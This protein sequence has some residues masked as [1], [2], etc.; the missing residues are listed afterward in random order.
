M[1][2][3]DPQTTQGEAESTLP[4]TAQAQAPVPPGK[5]PAMTNVPGLPPTG[6]AMQM[7]SLNEQIEQQR[8][9]DEAGGRQAMGAHVTRGTPQAPDLFQPDPATSRGPTPIDTTG[10]AGDRGV[11][12]SS[13]RDLA[14]QMARGY[15]LNFS[16]GSLVDD[17]G[18]FTMTP[19]QLTELQGEGG[20]LSDTAANMNRI[21][22]AINDQKIQMQQDK[23]TAALQAGA[24]LLQKR[25]RGSL[26]ALQSNFYQNMAAVYTDPNLLPEQQDF[27]YWI[28]KE[29]LEDAEEQRERE[30]SGNGDGDGG[31]G[32]DGGHQSGAD[33]VTRDDPY[34]PGEGTS[35]GPEGLGD[36]VTSGP[37]KGQCPRYTYDPIAQST[38][39]SWETC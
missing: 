5:N 1:T 20:D 38:T 6:L 29:G 34:N 39:I 9:D 7:S 35:S 2:S 24:G 33:I 10:G 37:H 21:A 14:E 8:M 28:Q 3:L 19:D 18:N 25:G 12:Q 17:Q 15:G 32:G 22:Q 23:A 16:G 30:D 11:G 26:A 13:L 27:S 4:G 36:K 31:G